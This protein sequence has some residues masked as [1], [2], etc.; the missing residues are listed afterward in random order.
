M[1]I[2][3]LLV[4]TFHNKYLLRCVF[5]LSILKP[6]LLFMMI[7]RLVWCRTHRSF[8]PRPGDLVLNFPNSSSILGWL[9]YGCLGKVNCGSL[10]VTLVT[11]PR[12]EFLPSTGSRANDGNKHQIHV[13]ISIFPQLYLPKPS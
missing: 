1:L 7:D 3:E 10:D 11:Y 2:K 13:Q 9:I 4:K 8:Y 5:N 6:S 12:V